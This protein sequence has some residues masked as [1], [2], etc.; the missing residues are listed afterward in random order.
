MLFQV[1]VGFFI[2][3]I[4]ALLVTGI[5]YLTRI[6]SFN[7]DEVE[8]KGGETISRDVVKKVILDE[9]E[10]AY[11]KLVP[12]R[13]VFTYP[14]EEIEES[15][16][17][18]E[19]LKD[20]T[21]ELS[22]TTLTI[23]YEEFRPYALWCKEAEDSRC[24]FIDE[25]GFAFAAAPPLRGGA[26]TRYVI[27]GEEPKVAS[28][29]L[30]RDLI[31]KT[32]NVAESLS[33]EFGFD[34]STIEVED[35]DAVFYVLSTGAILKTTIETETSE[36]INNI[37]YILASKDFSNLVS[38]RFEYIDLRYGNKVFVKEEVTPSSEELQTMDGL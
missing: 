35:R 32:E 29:A 34:V 5:W 26:F 12:K 15:I 6:E 10:G 28:E 36:L 7:I 24:L 30:S 17:S 19:R 1:F 4:I 18:I 23:T 38:G 13:F 3:S 22:G 14:K 33:V 21:I 8:V 25:E 2:V 9:L 31:T 20:V 27:K 16:H 11:F 37:K